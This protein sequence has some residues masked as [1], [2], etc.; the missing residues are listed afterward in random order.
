MAVGDKIVTLEDLKAAHDYTQS[1]MNDMGLLTYTAKYTERQGYIVNGTK[2]WGAVNANY[3]HV[4]IP[5]VDNDTVSITPGGKAMYYA[6]L[7]SDAAP[8]QGNDPPFSMAEE[9]TVLDNGQRVPVQMSLNANGSKKSFTIPQ[10]DGV[11]THYLLIYTKWSGNAYD[12]ANAL[13][14]LTINGVEL[15]TKSS[16][17][18][19]AVEDAIDAMDDYVKPDCVY[20]DGSAAATGDGTS[21]SPFKTIQ[22]GVNSGAEVVRVKA[23]SE[24]G[25]APFSVKNR[26]KPLKIMLWE[27][28]TFTADGSNAVPEPKIYITGGAGVHGVHVD[29]CAHV[30]LSDVWVDDPDR[31]CFNFRDVGMAVCTRCKASNN[32]TDEENVSWHGFALTNTNGV[33]R[34]CEA[35][36]IHKDGFNVH[37]FGD[38]HFFNCSAHGCG[39]DGISHH[40]SCVGLIVGGEYYNN[41]KG[42]VASPTHG[43]TVEV[44]GVYCYNNAYGLYVFSDN[45]KGTTPAKPI[46]NARVSNSVFKNNTTND[47]R[48][49]RAKITA[50]NL[51]YDTKSVTDS[52]FAEMADIGHTG[53]GSPA[54]L[55]RLA[56]RGIAG[57]VLQIGQVIYV[58]WTDTR[59]GSVEYQ[60][61][62]TIV[63]IGQAT[64]GNNTVHDGAVYLQWTY[65]VPGTVLYGQDTSGQ[66]NRY[67]NCSLRTWLNGDFFAGYPA[68]WQAVFGTVHVKTA[69]ANENFANEA[70]PVLTYDETN[71]KVFLPS[72]VQMGGTPPATKYASLDEGTAFSYWLGKVGGTPTNDADDDRKVTSLTAQGTAGTAFLRT[73]SLAST[74]NS[75]IISTAGA[76]TG[77]AVS[78]A[79]GRLICP[80]CVIY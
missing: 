17:R 61:P 53:I 69:I 36:N 13:K 75:Y 21:A 28:G 29:N 22:E 79:S 30:E 58:P 77:G 46:S 72:L 19:K 43:A 39:D 67:A 16:V 12:G 34:D 49:N 55:K 32:K 20:V 60:V 18:L 78:N 63:H 41:V 68:E 65:A 23:L 66:Y 1:Q 57:D 25:Y 9:F 37:G 44:Q 70:N 6:L 48:A 59:D 74:V 4:L 50:W 31:N 33:F 27:M 56:E 71:D 10:E 3:T 51:V 62:M 5:V 7:T 76:L 14:S 40:D 45:E 47:I 26:V 15:A 11:T 52:V 73:P 38:T 42:G 24:G 2:K 8:V 35:W 80:V 54:D 64:D